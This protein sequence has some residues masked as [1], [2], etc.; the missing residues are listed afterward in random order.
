M[1]FRFVVFMIFCNLCLPLFAAEKMRR[2]NLYSFPLKTIEH[3]DIE[4]SQVK[5]KLEL[6]LP[7]ENVIHCNLPTNQRFRL[8]RPIYP[9]EHQAL[10]AAGYPVAIPIYGVAGGYKTVMKFKNGKVGIRV[11]LDDNQV[12]IAESYLFIPLGV[13][14]IPNIPMASQTRTIMSLRIFPSLA[15]F[16]KRGAYNTGGLCI[17]AMNNDPDSDYLAELESR[18]FLKL[19][20]DRN[21]Q[22]RL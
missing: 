6:F 1:F 18:K 20:G 21:F 16:E 3:I 8:A 19:C 22:P 11:T 14:G 7:N 2:G 13:Q 4:V 9:Y 15:I 10:Y 5:G 17:Q 12:L